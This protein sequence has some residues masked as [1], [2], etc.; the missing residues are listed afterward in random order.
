MGVAIEVQTISQ[1]MDSLGLGFMS[2]GL[3]SFLSDQS[4]TDLPLTEVIARLIE[5]K[6]IPR[7]ERAAR[8]RL[9]LRPRACRKPSCLM[10]S[11]FP[12]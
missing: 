5:L 9:K 3:E 2:A 8:T 12:G 6:Y 1:R 4:H 10:I 7:K 11:S